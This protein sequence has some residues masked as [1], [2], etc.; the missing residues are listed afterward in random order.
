MRKWSFR[1]T[2]ALILPAVTML[3]QVAQ[4]Q[5]DFP[6]K[7]IRVIAPVPPGSPP[8]LV[9]RVFADSL[10]QSLGQPVIVDNRPGANQTIGLGAVAASGADGYT[11]GVVS[12]PTAVVPSLMAKMPYDTLRDFAPVRELAWSANVLIVRVE[13]PI[14]SV[15]DL[16]SAAKAQPG[17]LTFASGGNGTPAHVTAELFLAQNELNLVHVPFKG[18]LEGINAVMA[19]HVD[20]MLAAAGPVAP[21]FRGGKVKVLAQTTQSRLPTLADVPTFT[22][23]GFTGMAVRDWQGLV[24][25]ANT[26]QPVLARLSNAIREAVSR[27]EMQERLRKLGMEPVQDS[28]PERFTAFLGSEVKRWAAVARAS[29]LQAQ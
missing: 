7:T 28:D 26:P 17:K 24:A 1:L 21:Q 4:A 12:L 10:T 11:L 9:A 8:D 14:R 20:F 13:S 16:I 6:V 29:G 27:P 2:A 25:P 3:P 19:G 5:A 23:L 15:A 18:A 22:E